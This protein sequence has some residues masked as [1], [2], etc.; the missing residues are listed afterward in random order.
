[1]GIEGVFGDAKFF[2]LAFHHVDRIMKE[3]VG[4][5]VGGL[6]QKNAGVGMAF[7]QERNG[8][9]VVVM[10]VGEKKRIDLGLIELFQLG[11]RRLAIELRMHSGVQNNAG[12]S[13]ID[14][15]TIRA[16]LIG[17]GEVGE[18]GHQVPDG[19]VSSSS[20]SGNWFPG[21]RA[22]PAIQSVIT[23]PRLASAT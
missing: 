20:P 12:L 18:C 14:G 19:K 6:G 21:R 1:M 23:F 17:A 11:E 22:S 5:V 16:N 3:S 2:P 9:G 13:E 15:V 4:K 7:H 8:T 10:G